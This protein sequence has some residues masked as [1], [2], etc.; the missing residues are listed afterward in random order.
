MFQ[1]KRILL[2]DGNEVYCM[3]VSRDPEELAEMGG[4]YANLTL[5]SSLNSTADPSFNFSLGEV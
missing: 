4:S 3:W 5:A 1:I 2:D